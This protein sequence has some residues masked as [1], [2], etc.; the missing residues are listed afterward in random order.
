MTAA[1]TLDEQAG[2]FVQD[3]VHETSRT[4]SGGTTFKLDA[5]IS[6]IRDTVS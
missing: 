4:H 2:S 5:D 1:E 6:E 3:T